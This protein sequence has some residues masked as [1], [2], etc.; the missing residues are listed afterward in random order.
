MN[1]SVNINKLLLSFLLVVVVGY[2]ILQQF[3]VTKAGA[4][5]GNAVG[6]EWLLN[7]SLLK[8]SRGEWLIDLNFVYTGSGQAEIH[9]T[10]VVFAEPIG[11]T[12]LTIVKGP[13]STHRLESH[14]LTNTN[15][16]STKEIMK[17]LNRSYVI[18]KGFDEV[19]NPVE[20][21]ILFKNV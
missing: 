2:V 8:E 18:V 16:L 1:Y 5:E 6:E 4:L 19:G 15:I 10:R 12:I 21:K 7:Y 13:S 17:V 11:H 3:Q 20:E 14:V 9:E